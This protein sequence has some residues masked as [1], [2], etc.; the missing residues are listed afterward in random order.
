MLS[1][2]VY[3]VLFFPFKIYLC[4]RNINGFPSFTKIWEKQVTRSQEKEMFET[5]GLDKWLQIK[6]HMNI[7][8]N[9]TIANQF[10]IR[11]EGNNILVNGLKHIGSTSSGPRLNRLE[12]IV[13]IQSGLRS[14]S[15]QVKY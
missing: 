14:S 11:S 10:S 9:L 15:D 3:S 1:N 2:L 5:S 12:L 7:L 6:G 4:H 13:S 8:T